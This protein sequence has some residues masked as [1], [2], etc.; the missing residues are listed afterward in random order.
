MQI[1][2]RFI[3]GR[4]PPHLAQVVKVRAEAMAAA[5]RSGGRGHGML[6]VVGLPDAELDAIC[7]EA[8]VK[9]PEGTVCQVGNY[10]FPTVSRTGWAEWRTKN[11]GSDEKNRRAGATAQPLRPG[12]GPQYWHR[13][14]TRA[15]SCVLPSSILALPSL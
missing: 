5:A 9:L 3:I 14:S 1:N 10:L 8:R 12:A 15:P 4:A 6:S 2:Y 13:A 7:G 11:R